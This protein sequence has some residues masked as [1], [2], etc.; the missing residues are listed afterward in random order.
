MAGIFP[1]RYRFI[2]N[3]GQD[4]R[5]YIEVTLFGLP[6]MK[7]HE[8]YLHGASRLELPF[9]VVENEPKVNQAANLGLWAE[10]VWFPS[11]WVTDPRVRWER[12]DESTAALIVPFGAEEEY[13]IARFDPDTGLL[14]M[15]ESMR[16][17]E[18][19]DEAKTLWLNEAPQW[20]RIDG[21]LVPASGALT[22][23]DEGTPWA[24]FTTGEVVYNVPV[25]DYI[26]TRGP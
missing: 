6:V 21:N 22:W 23:I 19:D 8:T 5:H 13:F 1:A 17:K 2:H 25:D 18:A 10:A 4:Y 11:V 26:R 15:L 3:A 9:G 12:V 16:Y 14:R 24:V 20:D 7:V